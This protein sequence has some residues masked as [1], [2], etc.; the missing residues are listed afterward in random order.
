MSLSVLIDFCVF[1]CHCVCF[2][3]QNEFPRWK[4]GEKL[5]GKLGG[6]LGWKLGGKLGGK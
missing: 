3:T 2:I 5:G 4:L 1:V 6:K